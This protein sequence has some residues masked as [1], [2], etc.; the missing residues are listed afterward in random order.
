MNFVMVLVVATSHKTRGGITAVV[1]A[2]KQGKQ[3]N[4]YNC[5]WIETHI[6]CSRLQSIWYLLKAIVSYAVL[7]PKAS[8]VHIHLSEPTS[9]LRKLFFFFFANILKKKILV[10]FH[11]FSPDSTIRG[12][13]SWIYKYIFRHSTRVIVLSQKWKKDVYD[14]FQNDNIEVIYNPCTSKVSTMF[15]AKEKKILFAGTI[16]ERKGYADLIKAFAMIAAKYPD[17]KVVFAGNGEINQGKEWAEKLNIA[18][19]CEFLGWISNEEKDKVFKQSTIFCLP[20]YAEGFPMAVLDAWSYGLPV[21]TT[22][23]G[24]IPDIAVDKKNMLLFEAGNIEHLAECIELLITDLELFQ[25][26]EKASFDFSKNEFNV[27]RIN[28]QIE[29]M[30]KFLIKK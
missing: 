3:W 2:H 16:N 19:Q 25:K 20:S 8:I 29:S 30:Y 7:L 28:Q 1:N 18:P 14:T 15:Y 26:L 21:I 12:K 9:A 17:W 24:G 11:A 4:R 13:F 27:D 23:V 10:H 5:K 22:P 6:D